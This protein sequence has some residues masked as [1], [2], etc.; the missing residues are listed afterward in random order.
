M[1][2]TIHCVECK[3][4][5]VPVWRACVCFIALLNRFVRLAEPLCL[6]QRLAA[7]KRCSQAS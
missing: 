6:V 3:Q 1:L 4:V 5:L 7:Q 2:A